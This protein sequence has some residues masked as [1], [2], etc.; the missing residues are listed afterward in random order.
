MTG[1]GRDTVTT[2]RTKPRYTYECHSC[3]QRNAIGEPRGTLDTWPAR[4]HAE[5]LTTKQWDLLLVAAAEF[6][7]L[8]G[9]TPIEFLDWCR[10]DALGIS[11]KSWLK[12]EPPVVSVAEKRRRQG[13]E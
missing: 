3:H 1:P 5:P 10:P 12:V 7:E 13:L 11:Y 2:G 8:G 9:G 6:M 4:L